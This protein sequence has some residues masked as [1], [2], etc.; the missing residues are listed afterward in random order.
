MLDR[1]RGESESDRRRF[2]VK[3]FLPT[4]LRAQDKT[5][6]FRFIFYDDDAELC[7]LFFSSTSSTSNHLDSYWMHD[8]IR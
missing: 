4:A 5:V 6:G 7:P 3:R 8:S 1:E 2:D